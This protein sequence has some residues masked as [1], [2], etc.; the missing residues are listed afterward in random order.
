[1]VAK[2]PID[3]IRERARERGWNN[4]RL[5]SSSHNTYNRDYFA[6]SNE[7][8]Q[9]PA[10][11]VFQKTNDQIYHFYNSELLYAPTEPGQDPR[12]VDLIWPIWNLFDL[13]PQG[14]GDWRPKLSY[15][16]AGARQ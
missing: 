12:H 11:N 4:L 9:M 3:R 15:P 10:I 1:V 13:T 16:G 5:L 14:R 2:A 6:E 7:R 8:G